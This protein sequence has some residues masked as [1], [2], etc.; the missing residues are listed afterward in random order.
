MDNLNDEISKEF[1]EGLFVVRRTGAFWSG[2][3]PDLCIEQTLMAG[4]KGS[5]GLTRGR[6]LTEQSRLVWVLSRPAIAALDTAVKEMT[7]VQYRT[8]D[9]H[10]SMK[11][12][13]PST[14]NQNEKDINTMKQFCKSRYLLDLSAM[15]KI[16]SSLKNIATG[17]VAPETV[18]IGDVEVLGSNIVTDM[19]GKSVTTYTF[20]RTKQ[21][22]PL[23]ANQP[24]SKAN[25]V[26]IDSGLLFQRILT[27]CLKSPHDM[28]DAFAYELAHY[29]MSL[30]NDFGFMRDSQKHELG[31]L[32]HSTYLLCDVQP[33]FHSWEFVVDGGLLLHKIPWKK[34]VTY[35][36]ITED[37]VQY[38]QRIGDHMHIVFDGYLESNTKDHTHKRRNPLQGFK[39]DFTP[40]MITDCSKEIFLSNPE[41]KQNFIDLLGA[42]LSVAGF[43]VHFCDNDADTTIVTKSFD[44][45]DK[46]NV[47]VIADDTDVFILLLSLAK[48]NSLNHSLYLRQ[49][50]SKRFIDITTICRCIP[51]ESKSTLILNHAMSGCDTTSS[52]FGQGKTKLLKKKVLEESPDV[53]KVFYSSSSYVDEIIAA[54]EEIILKLYGGKCSNLNDLRYQKYQEY[55]CKS[56]R[57]LKDVDPRRLPPTSLS[58]ANHSLRT[59][60]QVQEWLGKNLD[61]LKYGWEEYGG[62]LTPKT[63]DRDIAPQ[64]VIKI[65]KCGCKT[66]CGSNKCS[67]RRAMLE[68]SD[69]CCC[70]EEKCENHKRCIEDVNDEANEDI[71]EDVDFV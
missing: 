21:A 31:S 6:S 24:K 26:E 36:D 25:D 13:L 38:V 3:S 5:T 20:K 8:S 61:P 62:K 64:N 2:V 55:L 50:A 59:Y 22:I 58:A 56:G 12:V 15:T 54:G 51:E 43:D 39:I 4:L 45:L 68:C 60:H 47:C 52:F 71:V 16:D 9:Q 65:L 17:L 63:M 18:T 19:V 14:M 42:N 11:H 66:N 46:N 34:G 37:Y 67:C 40:D 41:N 44:L 32:L 29:P 49:D 7:G 53:C 30:F 69:Y 33:D 23:P 1:R 48:D 27:A 57:T 70:S 35:N 28:K 10:L